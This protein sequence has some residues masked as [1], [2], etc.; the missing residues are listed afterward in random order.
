[1]ALIGNLRT[2][3]QPT[4]NISH[5]SLSDRVLPI[6]SIV[7]YPRIALGGKPH[8]IDSNDFVEM[9]AVN[10]GSLNRYKGK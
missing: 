1:M 2:S 7:I 9:Y 6:A 8:C 4:S 5:G 10:I 3:Q